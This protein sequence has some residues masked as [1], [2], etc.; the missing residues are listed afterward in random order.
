MWRVIVLAT[1]LLPS[2]MGGQSYAPSQPIPDGWYV[3]PQDKLKHSDEITL[4]CFNYSI[5]EWQVMT[6]GNG[7]RIT[8]RVAQKKGEAPSGTQLPPLLK[9]EEGMPGRTVYAGLR[10]ATHF[11]NGW[12]LAY[13][14]G[15]WGGGLWITNEDGS[16]AK[17]IVYDN[18][19]AVVPIDDEILVLS[20]L[21]HMSFD[22][23][24][25]FIFSKPNGLNISLRQTARLD[26]E[27]RAY[28]K[29]SDG[30]VL[31]VT[32]N[33]LSRIKK[34][35]E[36]QSLTNFP[37]WTRRQY[38]NSMTITSDGSIF[39]GMRMFVLKLHIDEGQYKE[40]W[41]LPQECRKFHLA[42]FDCTCKP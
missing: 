16:E 34:S 38:A 28:A 37:D 31:F 5:N 6:D 22:F 9:H 32:T 33:G 21:A 1:A 14:A 24:N 26:G 40:E 27:P 41:L 29:E 8:K 3:Y 2:L 10:S 36:V 11:S 19:H 20:G 15:E 23:G 25:A 12:L 30:S 17:R 7:I 13:D 18:V 39:V 42:K 35:G 4:R